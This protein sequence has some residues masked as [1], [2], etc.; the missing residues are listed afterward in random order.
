VVEEAPLMRYSLG[1]MK[2][3]VRWLMHGGKE[4]EKMDA[5]HAW[6]KRRIEGA[7]EEWEID[8]ERKPMRF[9]V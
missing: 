7:H 8:N 4:C 1:I 5:P 3:E 9:G 6:E 2:R